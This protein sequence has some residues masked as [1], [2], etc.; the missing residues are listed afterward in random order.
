MDEDS[1]EDNGEEDQR[2]HYK[3]FDISAVE[4]MDSLATFIVSLKSI[5]IRGL[6]TT[7]DTT[8]M[9]CQIL[10]TAAGGTIIWSL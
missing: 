3:M 8:N 6:F 1:Y 7:S 2:C 4:V 10:N 5:K 9:I